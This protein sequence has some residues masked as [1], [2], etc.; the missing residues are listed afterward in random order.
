MFD[1]RVARFEDSGDCPVPGKSKIAWVF[2]EYECVEHIASG[3]AAVAV[4]YTA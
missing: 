4:S 2:V 1:Y 3:D